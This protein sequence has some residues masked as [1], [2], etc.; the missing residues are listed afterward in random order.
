MHAL[1]RRASQPDPTTARAAPTRANERTA[2]PAAPPR[3]GDARGQAGREVRADYFA[4]RD[5][6]RVARAGLD[7][8]QPLPGRAALERSFGTGLGDVRVH[9]GPR[10]RAACE[11]LG[12]EAYAVG[13]DVAVR[14]RPSPWLLAHEVAHTIQQRRGGGGGAADHALEGE[15]DGAADAA[16]SGRAARVQGRAAAG[17]AQYFR[18][19]PDQQK[20]YPRMAAYV[21]DEMPK[22][23]NDEWLMKAVNDA[24]RNTGPKARTPRADLAWD[25]GP[26]LDVKPLKPRE[27][28]KHAEGSDTLQVSKDRVETFEKEKDAA[29]LPG[30]ELWLETTLLHEYVHFIADAREPDSE[31]W[32]KEFE[33]KAYGQMVGDAK[34]N[35]TNILNPRFSRG[36]FTV[37][38]EKKEAQFSQRF[39]VAGA[40]AGNGTYE[41]KAGMAAVAVTKTGV[42]PL[43]WTVVVEH[44]D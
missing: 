43:W 39:I 26:N 15:A 8:G 1:A 44:D 4:P 42:D 27:S 9:S 2:H 29:M 34:S 36:E 18:M 38:V 23:A 6:E 37:E 5:P 17:R 12:A 13:S 16:L 22:T 41:W 3:A 19:T 21:K 33:Q 30:H 40:D 24:S 35:V 10:A 14:G 11:R 20:L 25:A 31:E 7:G 32:G 28:G